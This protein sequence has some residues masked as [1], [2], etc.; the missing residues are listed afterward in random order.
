MCNFRCKDLS[1]QGCQDGNCKCVKVKAKG[2]GEV[3]TYEYD[4]LEVAED[5]PKGLSIEDLPKEVS[6]KDFYEAS[7]RSVGT[8]RG[9]CTRAIDYCILIS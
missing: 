1:C 2:E 3:T 5:T 7:R 8:V 4:C 6:I 9:W